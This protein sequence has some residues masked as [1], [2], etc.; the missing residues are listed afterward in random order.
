M[1][2]INLRIIHKPSRNNR[3]HSIVKG[4]EIRIK[5]DSEIRLKLLKL[6]K[7]EIKVGAYQEC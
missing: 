4:K 5:D 6:A 1:R 3:S 2:N 7:W